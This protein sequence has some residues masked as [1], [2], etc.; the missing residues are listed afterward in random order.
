MT[1][2]AEGFRCRCRESKRPLA[3]RSWIVV[4]RAGSHRLPGHT[5]K[6]YSVVHCLTCNATGRTKGKYV[7]RLADGEFKS[8]NGEWK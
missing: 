8:N 4:S 3:E 2:F 1:W 7:D 6:H 5:S